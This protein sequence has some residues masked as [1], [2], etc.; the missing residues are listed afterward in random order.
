MIDKVPM[1]P[2][3]Q[4]QHLCGVKEGKQTKNPVDEPTICALS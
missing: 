2:N 1:A 4:Y 3:D